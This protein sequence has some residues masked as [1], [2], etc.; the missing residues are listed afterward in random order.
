LQTAKIEG[1]MEDKNPFF[2]LQIPSLAPLLFLEFRNSEQKIASPPLAPDAP[3][4][5]NRE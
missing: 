5:N 3:Q 4:A 2:M 1:F